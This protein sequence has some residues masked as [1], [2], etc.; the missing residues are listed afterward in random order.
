MLTLARC[1]LEDRAQAMSDVFVIRN[2]LGHYWGKGKAWVDGSQPRLVQRTPHRD[3]AV[4]TLFELSSKDI[5]LR[6]EVVAAGLSERGEPLIEP[7]QVPLP[8][9]P[10][11]EESD[12][13]TG[14]R[15][16]SATGE[17]PANGADAESAA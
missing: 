5:D 12:G 1:Q 6:G 3:E 16:A 14:G 17:G 13:S 4:N 9:E 7:S 2:Q 8:L 15:D 10:S 11:A